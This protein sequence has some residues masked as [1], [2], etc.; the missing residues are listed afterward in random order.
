VPVGSVLL[1]GAIAILIVLVQPFQNIMHDVA[2]ILTLFTLLT[3]LSLFRVRFA[4]KDLPRPPPARL[5]AAVVYSLLAVW[6]LYYGFQAKTQL[7]PW[8]G[9]VVVVALGAYVVTKV[10]RKTKSQPRPDS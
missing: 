2:A 4:R 3:V 10:M 1:Q 5:A 9:I 7:L 6:M 8:I